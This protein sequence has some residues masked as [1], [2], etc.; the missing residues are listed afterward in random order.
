[1]HVTSISSP[2]FKTQKTALFVLL[3]YIAALLSSIVLVIPGVRDFSLNL[4]P[5]SEHKEFVLMAWWNTIA[6][7]IALV[8]MIIIIRRDKNFFN[9]FKEQRASIGVTIGWG[10]IGVFLAFSGQILASLIEVYLLG[11]K[12]GSEN[13]ALIM[14]I[15]RVAPIM[16][17]SS[18]LLAP[19]LEELIFRR[20]I[21]GSLIQ[22]QNFWVSALISA[23]VF[24]VIHRDLPHLLVYTV[25]GLIFSF[26]YFKTKRLLAPIIA[27]MLMNGLVTLAQLNID[28]IPQV[29]ESIPK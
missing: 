5:D 25:M 1:M 2:K 11:I 19:I 26:L 24:A 12:P 20:V 27:H 29:I 9:V 18:A 3:L 22:R 10:V 7:M 14:D 23:V 28:K 21:F 16:I 15:T 4:I 6:F 8:I 17:V 13:T